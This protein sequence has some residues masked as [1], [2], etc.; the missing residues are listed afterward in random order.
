MDKIMR[1]KIFV[2]LGADRVGK[3]TFIENSYGAISAFSTV[4][5]LH[6]SGPKPHHNNPIDQY[7]EPLNSLE[8]DK[9]SYVLCDRGFSEVCFYEKFRRN[10]IISEQWAGA[11][12]SY[13]KSVSSHIEVLMI[14]REWDWSKSK[15]IEEI[16]ELFPDA[17]NYFKRNQLLVREEEHKQYY[18]YMEEYLKTITTLSYQI[19][20][21][22]ILESVSDYSLV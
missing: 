17:S 2:I 20:Q 15:H 8:L 5:K 19:I 9:V 16:D 13:F 11:A 1:P 21:P 4:A 3:S 12:E 22:T 7:I 10:I 6:F 18:N 14:K